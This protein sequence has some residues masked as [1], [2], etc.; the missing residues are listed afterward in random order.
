MNCLECTD[1][2]TAVAVCG[3]CGAGLC[4]A[5]LIEGTEHLTVAVPINAR[6]RVEPPAR[7]LRCKQCHAAETAAAAHTNR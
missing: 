3:H 7:R 5:H 1:D 4:R 6:E 2:T